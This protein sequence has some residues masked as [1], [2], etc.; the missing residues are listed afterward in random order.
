MPCAGFIVINGYM[1]SLFNA[2]D[3]AATSGCLRSRD[4][5]SYI[6]EGKESPDTA[7]KVFE[8]AWCGRDGRGC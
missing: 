6:P 5:A 3:A 1:A 7:A 4:F 2:A 8:H